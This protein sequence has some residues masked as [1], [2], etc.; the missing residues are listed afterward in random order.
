MAF[1]IPT[2]T[3]TMVTTIVLTLVAQALLE[4]TEQGRALLHGNGNGFFGFL[5]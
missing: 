1:G 4:R 5:G 2:I 3:K